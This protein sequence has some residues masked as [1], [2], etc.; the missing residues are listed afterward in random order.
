MRVRQITFTGRKRDR[1]PYKCT[2]VT[3][4][5]DVANQFVRVEVTESPTGRSVQVHINGERVWPK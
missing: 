3:A 5:E 1:G 2:I 4:G